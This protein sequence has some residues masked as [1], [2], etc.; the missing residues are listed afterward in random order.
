M[1]NAGEAAEGP[2]TAPARVGLG[3]GDAVWVSGQGERV[4]LLHGWGLS[5][6][7]FRS[8]LERLSSRGFAVA[9]P[10]LAVVGRRWDL[11]RAVH[12]VT[13]ALDALEWEDATVVGYSLGGAVAAAFTAAS[14]QRV[15]LLALVNSVGLRIDRGMLGWATPIARYARAGNLPAVRAFG[16][17]AMRIR[18]LQ[19]L[20]DAATFARGANLD[21]EL[22]R[23]RDA[24]VPSVVLWSENDQLLPVTMGRR[25]AD[26]LGASV[27]V[28]PQA[29]H[30]WPVRAPE[31][32]ARELGL[33]LRTTLDRPPRR[34]RARA[35]RPDRP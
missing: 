10:S 27:H 20:A 6:H 33:L 4:V 29:D 2:T 9:V 22:A 19:N 5:P 7:V 31:L 13:K 24:R 12:R 11:A 8:T 26:A 18:G 35:S 14:P 32:F 3:R 17:N 15:R 28:V 23:V 16:R 34:R 30:D 1:D 21:A 25:I